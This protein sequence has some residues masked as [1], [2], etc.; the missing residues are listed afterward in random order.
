MWVRYLATRWKRHCT[1]IRTASRQSLGRALHPR[2]RVSTTNLTWS[3][4]PQSTRPRWIRDGTGATKPLRG[5]HHFQENSEQAIPKELCTRK[6]LE[7]KRKTSEASPLD[8][9]GPWRHS[10]RAKVR[11]ISW[12]LPPRTPDKNGTEL[13]SGF[14]QQILLYVQGTMIYDNVNVIDLRV[15][16]NLWCNKLN[17]QKATAIKKSCGLFMWRRIISSA[18]STFIGVRVGTISALTATLVLVYHGCEI[19]HLPPVQRFCAAHELHQDNP[20]SGPI[21]FACIW[22]QK[23]Q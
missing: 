6:Q 23:I 14:V 13:V 1:G 19:S 3:A 2:V 7:T 9:Q 21:T 11:A 16:C 18:R 4:D 12:S 17:K 10:W 22:S 15:P 5:L 20:S 8:P